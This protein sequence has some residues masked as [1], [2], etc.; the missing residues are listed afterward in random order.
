MKHLSRQYA[1]VMH[2]LALQLKLA[3][4]DSGYTRSEVCEQCD[5]APATLSKYL[6]GKMQPRKDA[7]ARLMKVI[8]EESIG[9]VCSAYL[10]DML[11]ANGEPY[12][13]ITGS[14]QPQTV[15]ENPTEYNSPKLPKE[16]EDA[17]AKLRALTG[18]SPVAADFILS[19]CRMLGEIG[20]P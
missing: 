3:L 6:N 15:S 10:M 11:P 4:E 19:T 18:K 1:H 9:A 20:E 17:F 2:R 7:L 5:I 8:P 14:S 16:L 13:S 12:V